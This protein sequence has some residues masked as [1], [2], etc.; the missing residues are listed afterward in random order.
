MC[1][2]HWPEKLKMSGIRAWIP[3]CCYI[4]HQW[5]AY[6]LC[7][8]CYDL[9]KQQKNRCYCCAIELPASDLHICGHCLKSPFGFDQT[10][11]AVSYVSPWREL[12]HQMKFEQKTELAM[13]MAQLL[14]AKLQTQEKASDKPDVLIP[15]PVFP[16]RM[17]TR[18][19]NQS[20]EMTKHLVRLTKVYS[21]PDILKYK[22]NDFDVNVSQA[23]RKRKERFK[24]L[25]DAFDVVD[26]GHDLLFDKHVALID[27]VMTTGATL[28]YAAQA[29]KRAGARRVSAWVFARTPEQRFQR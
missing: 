20:W 25:K 24:A 27:D 6:G 12:V 14:Y 10:I 2:A 17:R 26:E 21:S 16:Q 28:H 8:R 4:C 9:V 15:I 1:D 7:T 3:G 5:P 29:L 11:T 23:H 18:G 13:L 22:R 19:Y